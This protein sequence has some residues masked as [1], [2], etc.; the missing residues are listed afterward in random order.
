MTVRTQLAYATTG[1]VLVLGLVALLNPVLAAGLL[2]YQLVA[3]RALSEVR[4]TYGAFH[5]TMA[6]LLLWAVPLR[7]RAA[8]VVRV[9]GFLWSG[10]ALGRVASLAI[11]AVWTLA[12]VGLLLLQVAVAGVLV[13]VSFETPPPAAEVRARREVAAA[14]RRAAQAR[15][16]AAGPGPVPPGAGVGATAASPREVGAG[17]SDRP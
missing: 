14:R 3:P 17:R 11:D 10:A 9:V 5:V 8:W 13:W 15:S 1:V 16:A 6:A 2:G 7:P 12:N 4:A